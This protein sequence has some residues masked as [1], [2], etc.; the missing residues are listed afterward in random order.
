[1]R[2]VAYYWFHHCRDRRTL[3][4]VF[5]SIVL[6]A[7]AFLKFGYHELWKDEWQAWMIARDL[8]WGDMLD[9]LDYEGHPALWYIYLKITH[10]LT[11][12]MGLD[13]TVVMQTAHLLTVA[14]AYYL[15][16]FRLRFSAWLRLALGLGFFL[17]F[18]YGIVNRGYALTAMLSFWAV[19]L[20]SREPAQA[21]SRKLGLLTGLVFFLLFQTEVQG[22][23]IGAAWCFYLLLGTPGKWPGV[24]IKNF[25]KQPAVVG[26]VLGL[27]VFL[28]TEYPQNHGDFTRPYNAN[29]GT[30]GESAAT[31]FQGIFTNTFLIGVLPDTQVF[32]VTAMGLLLSGLTL[33]ALCW[34]FW[35]ERRVWAVFMSGVAA[36][37]LFFGLVYVGGVRQ[38][39]T[40]TIFFIGCLHLWSLRA[41][42]LSWA[43]SIILL[44]ILAAQ[45]AY[46]SRGVVKDIRYPFSNAKSAGIFIKNNVPAGVPVVAVNPFVATP[47]LGYAGR[48]FY[49][50][51]DGEPFSYFRW[52]DKVY[53]PPE[54]E[55]R[56]FAEY[57]KVGG[58]I[59]L[60][61]K[62]LDLKRYPN[63]QLW[64]CFD[65]Y[66]MKNENY[67]LYTLSIQRAKREIS[68]VFR[69]ASF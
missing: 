44:S 17:F 37:G 14:G 36:F 9:F 4:L 66:N 12:G 52:L 34:L 69:D 58:L 11:A 18:E 50:L 40:V 65:S 45:L 67:Y 20:A 59:V 54:D 7:L 32:G 38:W 6:A 63:L 60:S 53:L 61:G 27:L 48:K 26:W 16:F 49:A 30:L 28:W 47:V 55:L 3:N 43:Q 64:K 25:L 1:M 35:Q 41:P 21:N 24:R 29:M 62:P 31:A 23:I 2:P 39:G 42:R 68:A 13:E 33:A 19:D 56:L 57:K 5:F 22:G 51:P 15:L 46:C 10:L 8:S